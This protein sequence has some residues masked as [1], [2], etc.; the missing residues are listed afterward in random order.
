MQS[1]IR[2]LGNQGFAR[3]RVGIDRPPGRMDPADYVLQDFSATE[4][5]LVAEVTGRAVA[6]METWLLKGV[7][8]AMNLHNQGPPEAPE[9]Q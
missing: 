8:E 1:I 6:A 3:L 5:L 2:N 7:A 4:E 9:P